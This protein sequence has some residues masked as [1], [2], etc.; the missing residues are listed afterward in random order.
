VLFFFSFINNYAMN[1]T[2]D[3]DLPEGFSEEKMKKMDKKVETGEVKQCSIDQPDCE[4]C[5]G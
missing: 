4:N 5:S 1:I 3:F 2:H